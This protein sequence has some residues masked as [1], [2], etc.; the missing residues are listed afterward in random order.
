[1]LWHGKNAWTAIAAW[2]V[3][4]CCCAAWAQEAAEPLEVV[5][6]RGY[7]AH[8]LVCGP[9]EM[10]AEGGVAG[11]MT[12][13]EAPLGKTDFMA[14]LGGMAR[15]RPEHKMVA[16][17]GLDGAMWQ[18][19]GA[20][21]YTLDLSPFFPKADEGIAFAAFY[22]EAQQPRS[23]Y[24]ELDTPLGARIWRNG[25]LLREIRPAPLEQAG[26]DRAILDFLPGLNVVVFEVPGASYEHLAD[27][28]KMTVRELNV[29][30]M[31]NRTLLRGS[32]GFEI[33][34]KLQPAFPVGDLFY[35]PKLEAANTFSGMARDVSQDTLLT[36]FNP[37]E[38][39]STAVR[40]TVSA[41]DAPA[42]V[43]VETT[44]IPPQAE[45]VI[46]VPVRV[47]MR[48]PGQSIA[49]TVKL[50]TGE[51]VSGFKD[52]TFDTAV[53][54]LPREEGGKVYV[55]SGVRYT[56]DTPE[57]QSEEMEW[58]L[59][60]FEQHLR[61]A[62]QEPEYGFDLG[63][64]ALWRPLI[65]AYPEGRA[66]LRSAIGMNRCAAEAGYSHPDERYV[67]GEVL[68]RNLVYGLAGAREILSDTHSAYYAWDQ[69]GLAPQ[70]PQLVAKAGLPGIVSKLDV[71][72]L[73][74]LFLQESPDGSVIP[75]RH[76]KPSPGPASVEELRHLAGMQRQESLAMGMDSDLLAIES[77]VPPP[78]PFYIGAAKELFQGYPSLR[79]EGSGANSFF[80]DLRGRG[81]GTT[82]EL[83]W[84]TNS[85]NRAQPGDLAAQIDLKQAHALVESRLLTAETLAT[86][87]ALLGADY[88]DAALDAAWREVLY[89]SAP[90]RLGVIEVEQTYVDA[91]AGY[92]DAAALSSE[93]IDRSAHY[94]AA[95]ADTLSGKQGTQPGVQSLVV[96]NPTP[97]PRS[98]Y[99]TATLTLDNAPGLRLRD[100]QGTLVPFLA[101]QVQRVKERLIQRARVRFVARNI[102]AW[103]YRTFYVEP[104]GPLPVPSPR[105]DPQIENDLWTIYL[106][107]DSG[108]IR[109]I[110]DK[111]TGGTFSGGLINHVTALDEDKSQTMGG[112]ELW[113]LG[114]WT[115]PA[116]PQEFR[117]EVS[118]EMQQITV[119]STFGK[120]T[121]ERIMRVY[122]GVARIDCETKVTGMPL[123]GRLLTATFEPGSESRAPFYGERYGFIEG[124]RSLGILD[125]RTKGIENVSGTGVQPALHWAALS[126]GDG[127]QVG[128]GGAVPLTP[129]TIVAGSH[130]ALQK[131]ARL[132]QRALIHRG[133]PARIVS[134]VSLQSGTVWSDST[135]YDGVESTLHEGKA[136][137]I[138]IGN[139]EQNQYTGRIVQAVDAKV[140]ELYKQRLEQGAALYLEHRALPEEYG[141]A[142]AL[143]FASLLPERSAALAEEFAQAIDSRG[144]Y[145][146]P[147]S[148]YLAGQPPERADSGFA[149]LFPGSR[150]CSFEQDGTL[151]MLLA[152]DGGPFKE[153]GLA[154]APDSFVFRYA[155]LPFAGD[156]RD[157]NVPQASEQY[158]HPLFAVQEPTHLGILRGMHGF[159]SISEPGVMLGSIRAAGDAMARLHGRPGHPRDGVVLR[160]WEALGRNASVDVECFPSIRQAS[161]ADFSGEPKGPLSLTEGRLSLPEVKRFSAESYW[162]LPATPERL[163]PPQA[164][165]RDKD[166]ETPAYTRYWR[167][168]TGDAPAVLQAISVL[169]RGELPK[170][171]GIVQAVI[172]NNLVDQTVEGNAVLEA[173]DGWSVGPK[174]IYF[175]LRPGEHKVEEISLI[176]TRNAAGG[177]TAGGLS[178]EADHEGMIFR[179]TLDEAPDPLAVEV[180]RTGAQIRVTIRNNSGIPAKGM[181]ECITRPS[182]WPELGESPEVSAMPNRTSVNVAAFGEQTVLF[183]FSDPDTAAWA[184]VKVAANG[185]VCY[186]RVPS[187]GG[188]AST[189]QQQ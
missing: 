78:E 175:N 168:N 142:H 179:D 69:P 89:W 44:S 53:T 132:V 166:P 177:E 49:V 16:R 11:A 114:T 148:S 156:W 42:P 79:L 161:A 112:R 34:L 182:F 105:K 120:G 76:K 92:R 107:P 171:S 172:S 61:M 135:E 143:L 37:T 88:P 10:D 119:V 19:A 83:P 158:R 38:K 15:L 150:L 27:L 35:V 115:D 127:L 2:A 59:R 124:Q 73:P 169:L 30:A 100:D 121:L 17:P 84:R 13:S 134:D 63:P 86:F 23:A 90:A 39:P 155:L 149:L 116:T 43:L 66:I 167:H 183:R 173:T 12:R 151:A 153:D 174:Q 60:S 96:F 126:P 94:I 99:C 181:A 65:Q 125:F 24:M 91:L 70:T 188:A 136:L 176:R 163:G 64:A 159:L 109:S 137:H 22:A 80:E 40:V 9:F 187:T 123:D 180:A 36:L 8:W 54:V 138:V 62:E 3:G 185:H 141:S 144:T 56:P 45:A 139:A 93:I 7:V 25:R 111:K 146:L 104:M 147:P 14:K 170:D 122:K 18:R 129:A 87:A 67:D 186:G 145:S 128:P 47:G 113:T 4:L 184:A 58:R 165:G 26:V 106:D 72:G 55:V 98:D 82:K 178:I 29:H 162:L 108:G 68:A 131:A 95:Q 81:F 130:P 102:P 140:V 77:Q 51:A 32:S 117:L 71:A 133:I 189:P 74:G 28:T 33:A 21:S 103:G 1:M 75:H 41:Q 52:A 118:E 110:V 50:V 154:A 97:W 48:A 164:L 152:H 101:G 5:L 57:T 160:L 157:G 6:S 46:K 31:A 85:M 20:K